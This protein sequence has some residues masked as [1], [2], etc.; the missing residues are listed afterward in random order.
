MGQKVKKKRSF[1]S[2]LVDA[3][4]ILLIIGLLATAGWLLYREFF[5]NNTPVLKMQVMEKTETGDEKVN[6]EK[7]RAVNP[8]VVG[9]LKIEGTN[10]DTPIVQTT[11]NDKYLYTSF[12]GESDE[13]GVPFL[14]AAYQ[15]DPKSRN[16]VIYGHSTMRSKVHVMF[17]DLLFYKNDLSFVDQHHTITYNRPPELGGDGTWEIV[18][19]LIEEADYDYRQM[20]FSDEERFVD[21]Y[22]GMK[23]KSIVETDAVV[24]PGDEIL[25][26]STCIFNVGLK[27]GRLAVIAK[28]V[29]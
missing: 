20:D 11:D 7:L 1:W 15:W 5:P 8:E 25:T 21:Y 14:D 23:A 17:D 13:R 24:E 26:L 19:I 4:I 3:L 28:R 2:R 22:A 18:S 9:W 12:D 16:S 27:D 10:I 6:W 29:A